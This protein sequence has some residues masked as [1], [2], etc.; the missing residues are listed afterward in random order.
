MTPFLHSV[1]GPQQNR[2]PCETFHVEGC[3]IGNRILERAAIDEDPRDERLVG[4]DDLDRRRQAETRDE[5][6]APF[7]VSLCL[8]VKN[9]PVQLP[10]L[11]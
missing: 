9:T 5:I 3:G 7:S 8:C 11:G 6:R 10:N 1:Q 4:V 2:T